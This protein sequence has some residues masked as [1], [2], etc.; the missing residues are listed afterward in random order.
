MMRTMAIELAPKVRVNAVNPGY[1]MTPMQEAEYSPDMLRQV[2]GIIPMRRHA[3]PEE[4]ASLYVY[5]ASDEA[6]GMLPAESSRSTAPR[7]SDR[8]QQRCD[9]PCAFSPDDEAN[10]AHHFEIIFGFEP[11][12]LLADVFHARIPGSAI[13][14]DRLVYLTSSVNCSGSFSRQRARSPRKAAVTFSRIN[15]KAC[16][17]NA[18]G[19]RPDA[20]AD[21]HRGDGRNEFLRVV[22]DALVAGEEHR[23]HAF[24]RRRK[25]MQHEFRGSLAVDRDQPDLQR[26][27]YERADCPSSPALGDSR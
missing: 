14:V 18:D 25:G 21:R 19:R 15:A 24:G 1:T 4:I 3:R 9:L 23:R 6:A 17:G 16:C 22:A 27:G 13:G 8:R 10:G 11:E 7:A 20:L 26:Q 2:N 12:G 5:L